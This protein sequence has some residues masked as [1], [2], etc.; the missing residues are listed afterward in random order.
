ML[1]FLMFLHVFANCL[2]LGSKSFANGPKVQRCKTLFLFI[3][4]QLRLPDFLKELTLELN[5]AFLF[6]G[7]C[8]G[9]ALGEFPVC[10]TIF[11]PFLKSTV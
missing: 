8:P 7:S 5:E 10:S 11:N 9:G 1:P 2:S 4:V 6:H 3:F